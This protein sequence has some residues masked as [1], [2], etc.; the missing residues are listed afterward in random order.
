MNARETTVEHRRLEHQGRQ[1]KYVLVTPQGAPGPHDLLIFFHGSL[2]SGNVIR[3][4]T[5]G[6]FDALD[7]MQVAY[8]YG[9]EQHFNDARATLP[10]AA[11]ELGID[12]VGFTRAVVRELAPRRVFLAGFSNGGQMVLRLLFDA[13]GLADA[14]VVFASTLGAGSN[15]APTNPDSAFLPTPVLLMHGTADPLAP[16][17]GG[18]AGLDVQRTRGPVLGAMET[19]ARLAEL[20]GAHPEPVSEQIFG[21]TTRFRWEGPAPVEL[22]RVAGM[23]HLI[24]SGNVL[25]ARLGRNTNSFIAADLVAEFFR[26]VRTP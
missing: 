15:H 26:R 23:G 19:A 8:P 20:N 11:R 12:D 22:L 17:E 2:Q 16:Y 24:P 10:V 13:P 4:F 3:R 14:A 18:T 21:D 9:V 25:D 6:T 1:R 5:A 7:G